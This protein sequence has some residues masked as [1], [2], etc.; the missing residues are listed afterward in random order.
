MFINRS[1]MPVRLAMGVFL[2]LW[3][4][5]MATSFAESESKQIEGS[6]I[7]RL[8][9]D[10]AFSFPVLITF[11]PK[12]GVV[13][14]GLL[15]VPMTNFPNSGSTLATAGHGAWKKVGAHE[16]QINFVSLLQGAP[17]NATHKG[18][19][20]GTDSFS[21]RVKLNKE[22]TEL[23]GEFED[24]VKN[25]DGEVVFTTTGTYHATRIRAEP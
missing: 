21:L 22:G 5:G 10:L 7:G 1:R 12:G 9:P 13:A 6:W 23:D 19:E 8:T 14:S 11:S 3:A 4:L 24:V 16:F 17:D 2:A 15:Y 20:L 25:L 18:V